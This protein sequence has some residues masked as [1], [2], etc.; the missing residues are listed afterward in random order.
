MRAL[1]LAGGH[2]TR[3]WPVTKKRAKPLL[4]LAGKPILSYILDDLEEMDDVEKIY[5]TTN[6]KFEEEFEEFLSGRSDKNELI[7][8]DQECE[9][10][11]YGALGGILNVIKNRGEDDYLVIGGDNYYSFDL[12]DF[13]SFSLEKGCVTNACYELDDLEEAKSYGIVN[14]NEGRKI[15]DF[16]E[17]PDEPSSKT[18][19]TAC[20]F[21]PKEKLSLFDNYVEYWEGKVPKDEYLDS[22]GTLLQ[23]LVSRY[24]C[25]AYPFTGK[26]MDIGTRK[27]YLR[28]TKELEEGNRLE[29][30][31]KDSDVEENVTVMENSEVKNSELENCIVLRGAEVKDSV[32]KDS[33]VGRDTVLKDKDLRGGIVKGL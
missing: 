32:V 13:I 9:D 27:G 14:F 21:F 15:Q 12:E 31:V 25:Y 23:W 29:G 33:I 20:Y 8:E 16:E 26:W 17:K 5:V 19:S 3:L 2:A 22:P 18:A 24:D 30:K 11:K 28:A 4:P 10:E 1:I 7:I 6:Q